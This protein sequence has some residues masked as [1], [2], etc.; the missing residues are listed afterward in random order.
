MVP[1]T[2]SI[3][4]DHVAGCRLREADRSRG[5]SKARACAMTT[6]TGDILVG[7]EAVPGGAPGVRATNPKTGAALEPNFSF[8]DD[9]DVDRAAR[10]AW[11]AFDAFRDSDLEI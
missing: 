3:R 11:D 8:A 9:D 10:R 6:I 2:L 4:C 7:G 5:D 1:P